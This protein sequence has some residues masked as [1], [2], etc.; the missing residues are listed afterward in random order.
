MGSGDYNL[1]KKEIFF[2]TTTRNLDPDFMLIA[3]PVF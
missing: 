3:S 2:K 1:S